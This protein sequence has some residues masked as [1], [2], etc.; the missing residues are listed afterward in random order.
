[1]ASGEH[2]T[3]QPTTPLYQRL[4][5]MKRIPVI[6]TEPRLKYLTLYA[7]KVVDTQAQNDRNMLVAS[8]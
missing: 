7:L 6:D 4:Q 2:Q 3:N 1:M 5:D 8:A